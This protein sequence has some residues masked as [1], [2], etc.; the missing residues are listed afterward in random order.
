MAGMRVVSLE[1]ETGPVRKGSNERKGLQSP[2]RKIV[3]V[4]SR[5][6]R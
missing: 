4:P 2:Y 3:T 1:R 5:T 6:P